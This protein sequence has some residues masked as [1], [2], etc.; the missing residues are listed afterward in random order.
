MNDKTLEQLKNLDNE[1]NQIL[2]NPF[3]KEPTKGFEKHNPHKKGNRSNNNKQN[4]H[5]QNKTPQPN[6]IP[7]QKKHIPSLHPNTLRIIP[8]G[9]VEEVGKNCTVLE[10]GNDMIIVDMGLMFP[11]AEMHGVQYLIPD[12]SYL[13]ANKDKIKGILITHGHLDHIG[14]IPYIM[15]VLDRRIPIYGSNLSLKLIEKRQSEF[16]GNLNLR[17]IK[18]KDILRLGSF[19]IEFIHVNH[20]I[21]GCLGVLIESPVG[22]VVTLGDW[23]IDHAPIGDE[24]AD[25]GHI[26]AIGKKNILAL[27]ADSTNAYIE[28]FQKSETEVMHTLDKVYTSSK[29][30][31]I[32]GT[33]ASS[34]SRIQQIIMLAEKHNRKVFFAGYSMKTNIEIAKDLQYL[35]YSQ[36]TIIDQKKLKT[37]ADNQIVIACT[38]VQGEQNAA[39]GRIAAGNHRD[40]SIQKGDNIIFSSSVIP[41]NEEPIQTLLDKIYKRGGKVINIK[42]MAVHSG[43]H[44]RAEEVKIMYNLLRPTYYFPVHGS[45]YLLAKHKELIESIGHKSEKIIIPENGMIIEFNQ[46][47][48]LKILKEKSSNEIIAVDGLGVGDLPE[49]VLNDRKVMANSGIFVIVLNVDKH[50]KNIMGEPEVISRGFVYLKTSEQLIIDTKKIVAKTYQENSDMNINELKNKIRKEVDNFLYKQTE[51]EPMVIPLIIKV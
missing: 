25:L 39:L 32:V 43:G 36:N 12:F 47:R 37:L 41:G 48:Q 35:K 9:G 16:G 23:K 15:E 51:R 17:S 2:K 21:P 5:K 22:N 13:E 50:S 45:Y 10:Y 38:G 24:S 18:A 19:K 31:I 28:G 26:A 20:T 6:N 3:K 40:I 34:L 42:E 33:F 49:I 1:L 30:R 44:A 46:A 27:L 11:P 4:R 29:G 7:T 8:L 14:A